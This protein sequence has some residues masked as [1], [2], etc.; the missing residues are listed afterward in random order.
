MII[1][2]ISLPVSEALAVWPGDPAIHITQPS[3]LDKGDEAT[4]SR[5]D[6]GAHTG[7]H[8]DAPC[9]YIRG[10]PGID[11]LD[12]TTLVGSALVVEVP[13][14]GNISA[15]VLEELAIPPGTRRVLFRTRNSELLLADNGAFSED[16]VGI[17]VDGAQ[18]LVDFGV[19]LVGVDYLSVAPFS[20]SGPTHHS[21]LNAG[22]IIVEGLN[23]G[24][25]RAGMYTLA[26]LPL[27]LV[28]IDGSPARAILIEDAKDF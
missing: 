7:T 14:N 24:G 23:L 10:G 5:L 1:H 20:Q 2:D 15:E 13:S 12:L 8:V 22:V 4:V 18:W 11:S 25:I 6:I 27:K 26:C 3:H 28:G 21:L 19:R 16:F 17:S 9:H